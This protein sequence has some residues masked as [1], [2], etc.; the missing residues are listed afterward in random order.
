MIC[1]NNNFYDEYWAKKQ[2]AFL[3]INELH[4]TVS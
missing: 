3:K 1:R 4:N 2:S